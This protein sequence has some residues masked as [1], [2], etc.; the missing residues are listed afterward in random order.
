M[1]NK[2]GPTKAA[3]NG[4]WHNDQFGFFAVGFAVYVALM[5]LEQIQRSTA[6]AVHLPPH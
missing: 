2:S 5:V 6:S 3:A 1:T 4:V